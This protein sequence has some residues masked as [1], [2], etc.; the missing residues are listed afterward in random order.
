MSPALIELREKTGKTRAAVAADLQM[1]ERH[2]YRLETGAT[3]LSRRWALTF[4]AYFGV[5]VD[6]IDEAAA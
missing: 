5:K 2:L 4:A 3:P 1:S 6:D